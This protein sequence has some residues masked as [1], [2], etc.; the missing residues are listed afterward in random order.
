MSALT[1]LFQSMA[2]KI[3]SKTG[4]ATTYT[5]PQMVSD[6]ID[7]VFDAGVASATTSIT[8]SNASP[9]ALTADTGYKPTRSGYAIQSYSTATPN[10]VSP[11][12][13][14]V[15]SI[16]QIGIMP[17]GNNGYLIKNYLSCTPSNSS[18]I[19]LSSGFYKVSGT[20]K[21]VATITDVTPSS[22]PTSVSADDIVHIGGSGVIVDS[23]PTP[24]SITPSNSSPATITSGGLYSA[25]A[26]GNAVASIRNITPSTTSVSVAT[27]DVVKV[28]GSGIIIKSIPTPTAQLTTLWENSSYTQ[29]FPAQTVT[30][31]KSM[32]SFD[33]VRFL[34]RESKT[35]SNTIY[36]DTPLN[37]ITKSKSTNGYLNLAVVGYENTMKVR[38]IRYNGF[39]KV[40]FTTA[41]N[42]GEAGTSDDYCIPRG[43]YGVIWM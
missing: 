2:N 19:P 8:P 3:R 37:Q 36:F 9:V 22:S 35:S 15:D 7:D 13:L 43:I 21:A 24:T 23:I 1:D 18:P 10:N 26:S 38:M 4:T 11:P 6:G 29:S 28:G 14:A 5:P 12:T 39:S 16:Y 31:S 33:A 20:G 27:N 25:T 41:Y 32:G 17:S 34:F 30:L 42:I 40:D